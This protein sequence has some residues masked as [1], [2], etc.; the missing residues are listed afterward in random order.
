MNIQ[1]TATTVELNLTW[2]ERLWACHVGQVISVSLEHV[3][4]I[5]V[6]S[7]TLPWY[8]LR[9][10]GTAIPGLFFAGTFYTQQGREFWYVT[11]QS[12]CL[13]LTLV[14]EYYKRIV[15]SMDDSLALAARLRQHID[16][17]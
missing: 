12:P 6:E 3:T 8:A 13:V 1:L 9:A 7:P 10:P 4:Q 5:N 16:N 2:H 15:L 17:E 14:D 11:R